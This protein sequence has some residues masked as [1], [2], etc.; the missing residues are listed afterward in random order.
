MLNRILI[1]AFFTGAGQ[2]FV[3]FA[4]KYISHRSSPEQMKAIAQ[5]DSLLL[6]MMNAIALG[7]QPAA[8]RN[9]ALADEW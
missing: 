2:V 8:K 3:V 4:L 1:I 5:I 6:F 7:L 9:L